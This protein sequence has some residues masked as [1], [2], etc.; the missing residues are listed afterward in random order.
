MVHRL[1]DDDST[2]SWVG[3]QTSV[4]LLLRQLLFKLR[5]PP[6]QEKEIFKTE[7]R[8]KG[9]ADSSLEADGSLEDLL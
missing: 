6:S 8:S 4:F 2:R 5:P 7:T 3:I 9:S 1:Y